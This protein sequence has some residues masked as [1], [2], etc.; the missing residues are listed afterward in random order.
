MQ[1]APDKMSVCGYLY[2]YM[3]PNYT[4]DMRTYRDTLTPTVYHLDDGRI[5]ITMSVGDT[6]VAAL[7]Y[8]RPK[9]GWT[10]KPIMPTKWRCVDANIQEKFIY[11]NGLV[12]PKDLVGWGQEI[13]EALP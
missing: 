6:E 8:E 7:Y 13:I 2:F 5:R 4:Y 9:K 1:V 10:N 11:I 3:F 12:E